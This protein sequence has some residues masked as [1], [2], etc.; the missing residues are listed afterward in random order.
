MSSPTTEVK[1]S[2]VA[3]LTAENEKLKKEV[4][5]LTDWNIE[6]LNENYVPLEDYEKL[7]EENETLKAENE[8]LQND[9]QKGYDAG[10]EEYEVD[11]EYLDE[12]EEE[13]EKLKGRI[14]EAL[15]FMNECCD[16]SEAG[17]YM[18]WETRG[19]DSCLNP[20]DYIK[21]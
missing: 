8:K 9:F 7:K 10:R 13:I 11:K 12:K 16:K 3:Q 21:A 19:I 4:S 2:Q 17:L 14:N 20:D 18:S 15:D 1:P 6:K 5:Y